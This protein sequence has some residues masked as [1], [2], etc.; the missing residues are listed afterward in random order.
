MLTCEICG[1]TKNVSFHNDTSHTICVDCHYDDQFTR[2]DQER[3]LDT[4]RIIDIIC[5]NL[6]EDIWVD[7]LTPTSG[8]G[9][10][11]QYPNKRLQELRERINL[12]WGK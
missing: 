7:C 2:W 3:K 11:Y 4:L 5:A 12:L 8:G 6:A 1:T 9:G 10:L